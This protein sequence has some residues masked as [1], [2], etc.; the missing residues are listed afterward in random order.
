MRS[1]LM[2]GSRYLQ[3]TVCEIADPLFDSTRHRVEVQTA[4]TTPPPLGTLRDLLFIVMDESPNYK[5]IPVRISLHIQVRCF[6]T[7]VLLSPG[8]LHVFLLCDI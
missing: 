7:P 2:K 6:D 4:F 1:V 5:V 3:A 8:E